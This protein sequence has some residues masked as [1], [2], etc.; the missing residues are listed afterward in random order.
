VIEMAR[1]DAVEPPGPP[2]VQGG[3][4]PPWRLTGRGVIVM[5]KR[6]AN[7]S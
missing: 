5:K 4:P 6:L 1:A 3:R 7:L 2:P